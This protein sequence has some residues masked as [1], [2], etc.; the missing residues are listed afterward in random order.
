MTP[1]GDPSQWPRLPLKR[2]RGEK[3]DFAVLFDLGASMQIVEGMNVFE[4]PTREAML[5]SR[6]VTPTELRAEGWQLD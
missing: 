5:R 4:I 2:Y 3:T 6:E 1:S